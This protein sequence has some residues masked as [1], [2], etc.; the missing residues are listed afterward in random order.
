MKT[1]KIL[2]LFTAIFSLILSSACKKDDNSPDN[3]ARDYEVKTVQAPDAMAQ[4]DDP[5]AQQATSYIN[6]VNGMTGYGSMM[7]PPSKSTPVTN[8]KDGAGDVYIWEINEGNTHCTFTL[9]V[10]ESATMYFWEMIIDGT[11]DGQVFNNFVY[12]RAE[13]A[14][15]GS[16]SSFTVYDPETGGI[17]MTMSWYESGS[18]THLTFEVPNSV[19]ISMVVNADG[20]GSVEVK[21][22]QNGQYV[23]EFRAEWDASGHGQWWEYSGGDIWDQGSW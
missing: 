16:S 18:S 11:L 1:L 7:T 14:K 9:K 20:S 21:S 3:K 5:G 22:W 8:F 4:S 2:L 10:S 17:L 13:E 15:D 23:L 12:M 19:L 6:M